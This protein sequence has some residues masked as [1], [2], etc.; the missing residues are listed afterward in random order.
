MKTLRKRETCELMYYRYE[1][2]EVKFWATLGVVPMFATEPAPKSTLGQLLKHSELWTPCLNKQRKELGLGPIEPSGVPHYSPLLHI[3]ASCPSLE[4]YQTIQP[5][6]YVGPLISPLNKT[7]GG[8]PSWWGEVAASTTTGRSVVGITQGTFAMD[9]TS[10]IIP[11][12]LALKE[13]PR[14]LLVVSTPYVDQVQRKLLLHLREEE[15][16]EECLFPAN[17]RLGSWVPYD[18]LL[19]LPQTR[20]LIT[21]GGYGSVTQALAHGVPLICAGTTEDKKD[22]AARMASV[23]AGIDLATDCPS[24]EQVRAAVGEI[25]EGETL[26][27]ENAARTGKELNCLGGAERACDLLEEAA[28]RS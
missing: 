10:L 17:L 21:N 9:P 3:Q 18:A 19:A 26:Y 15:E 20:V 27:R 8:L 25:L 13:D 14:L 4:Y 12:I 11:A 24:V 1:T 16:Q 2:K 5:T 7:A 22:T 6:H 23:G 28:S